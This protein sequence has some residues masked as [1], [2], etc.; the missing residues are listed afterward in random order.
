[1]ISTST[2]DE[3]HNDNHTHLSLLFLFT[4]SKKIVF[5]QKT[6]IDFGLIESEQILLW[7]FC[8]PFNSSALL[9]TCQLIGPFADP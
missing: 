6:L 4:S 9:P 8:H 3:L 5:F 2:C 7:P 1:M